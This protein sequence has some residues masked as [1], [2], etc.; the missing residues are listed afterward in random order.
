MKYILD[1]N[2]G[3]W[4]KDADGRA[5]LVWDGNP[6]EVMGFLARLDKLQAALWAAL[7]AMAY[8]EWTYTMSSS[9]AAEMWSFVN[10]YGGGPDAF[11]AIRKAKE[12]RQ[13]G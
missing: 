13:N 7:N 4:R 8:V 6:V 2:G 12:G 1:G 3:V 9:A 11:A 5:E 10:G